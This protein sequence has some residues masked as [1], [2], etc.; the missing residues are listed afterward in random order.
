MGSLVNRAETNA[1]IGIALFVKI[2]RSAHM[3]HLS[4]GNNK[5]KA[6]EPDLHNFL[7]SGTQTSVPQYGVCIIVMHLKSYKLL[8]IGTKHMNACN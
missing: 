4:S 3:M 1:K 2:M 7:L 5:L 6:I 8:R